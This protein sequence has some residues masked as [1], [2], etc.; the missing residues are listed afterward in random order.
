MERYIGMDVHAAS[1][2][3]ARLGISS[4]VFP[5]P[6]KYASLRCVVVRRLLIGRVENAA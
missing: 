2:T 3:L 1:C 6:G 5:E 4:C